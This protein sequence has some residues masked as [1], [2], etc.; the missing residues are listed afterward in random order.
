MFYTSGLSFSLARNP[1][2][3]SCFTLAANSKLGGYVPPG[4]NRIST[5]LLENEKKHVD[6]SLAPIKSTWGAKGVTIVSDGWSNPSM[7]SLINF[8]V[9]SESGSMFMKAVDCSGEFKGGDFL[10]RLFR[11]VIDEVGDENVV[12]VITDNASNCKAAGEI[13][14]GYYPRIYWTSC[15]VHTLNPALKNICA[16]R[17]INNNEETYI[18][19]HLISEIHSDVFRIENFIVNHGMGLSIYLRF[20]ALKLLSVAETRF[21][22]IVIMLK[23]FKIVK[24]ALESMVVCDRWTTYKDD[25]QAKARFARDTILNEDWWDKKVK[26]V[27]Y[28]HEHIENE[29]YEFASSTFFDNVHKILVARWAKRGYDKVL[30]DY[31][32]FSLGVGSFG[33]LD[34]IERRYTMNPRSWWANFGAGAL[35]LQGLAIRLLGQPTSSSCAERNWSTYSFINSVKR[36]KLHLKRAEDLVFIH[37]N[38]RLLSRNNPEYLDERTK[39]W[40]IGS[41]K[42]GTLED[43]AILELADLS[44]D[45]PEMESVLF[46]DDHEV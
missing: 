21:A 12:Q 18:E 14:E 10:A 33:D 4:Y 3:F 8:I 23:R 26:K 22:S 9:C 1:N 5:T 44:L 43:T 11:E 25:D 16:A 46:E 19:C 20:S 31:G 30:T 41:D 32:L 29:D 42:F 28:E 17:N 37:N 13:I 35:L 2:Y 39:M 15:V 36:N 24:S 7:R 6:L 27:I 45:E 38:L 34:A 40:D